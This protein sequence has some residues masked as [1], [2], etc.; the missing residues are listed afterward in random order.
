M[1]FL[2][3]KVYPPAP[4]QRCTLFL[5]LL[6]QKNPP[7]HHPLHLKLSDLFLRCATRH[8]HLH[9]QSR[10]RW[11]VVLFVTSAEFKRMWYTTWRGVIRLSFDLYS[12]TPAHIKY[13]KYKF[14]QRQLFWIETDPLIFCN[15]PKRHS[16]WL[17]DVAPYLQKLFTIVVVKFCLVY[18]WVKSQK[19]E[20]PTDEFVS[21]VMRLGSMIA[22]AQSCGGHSS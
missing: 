12:N 3:S 14:S 21:T 18:F 20:F 22:A 15:F 7:L 6:H 11:G 19:R 1:W 2:V 16:N 4:L 13:T 9:L 8:Q 10:W 5:L 17:Y